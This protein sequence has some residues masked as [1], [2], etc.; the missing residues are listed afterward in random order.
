MLP[1]SRCGRF[2]LSGREMIAGRATHTEQEDEACMYPKTRLA[3]RGAGRR[4]ARR[5]ARRPAADARPGPALRHRLR[6]PPARAADLPGRARA[7]ASRSW[8]CRNLELPGRAGIPGRPARPGD[9][10]LGRDR[11][12]V[13]AGRRAAARGHLGRPGGPHVGADGAAAAGRAAGRP[14]RSWPASRCAGCAR[15]RTRPRWRRCWRRARRSTGC[16]P[17]CRAGCGRAGPRRRWPPTSP[18]RSSAEGHA[19]VDFAIVGSGPERAPARTTRPPAGCCSPATWWWSTSAAPCR[20]ATART[21]PGP[22]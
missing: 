13:R 3:T 18:T 14:R 15:A 11:R 4:D 7:R 5:G 6:R 20:A 22:T 9:H 21:A 10:R 2:Q 8:S 17:G 19:Q 1:L 12:P 16:T